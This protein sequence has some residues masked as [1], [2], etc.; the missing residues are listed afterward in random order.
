MQVPSALLRPGS[1]ARRLNSIAAQLRCGAFGWLARDDILFCF[2]NLFDSYMSMQPGVVSGSSYRIERKGNRAC[3]TP[4]DAQGHENRGN[5]GSLAALRDDTGGWTTNFRADSSLT[6]AQTEERLGP[7]ALRMTFV[8][9]E[10]QVLRL[11]A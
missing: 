10:M 5:R 6:Q 1:S 9:E 3:M 2:S 8:N 11:A 4:G 7:R